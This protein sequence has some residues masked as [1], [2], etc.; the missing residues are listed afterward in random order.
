MTKRLLAFAATAAIALLTVL[1]A[2]A[3][4]SKSCPSGSSY[5]KGEC[6]DHETGEVVKVLR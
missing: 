5:M 2:T 3:S 6:I 1:D 4:A